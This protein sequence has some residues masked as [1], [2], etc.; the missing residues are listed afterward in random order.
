M[1]RTMLYLPPKP[2]QWD[3]PIS[4][5]EAK[6]ADQNALIWVSLETPSLEESN[7]V[8]GDIFHFH[9][10][11]IEDSQSEGYQTPKL[12]EFENYT[13]I[14]TM[15]PIIDTSTGELSFEE[16]N[17]F[18][19]PN[20]VVTISKHSQ[21]RVSE[22]IRE[23]MKKDS[24]LIQHGSDFF[25]HALIDQMV[26][27]L[28]LP[29]EKL[30]TEIEEIEDRLLV[31]SN[32]E[33]LEDVLRHKH[34][35]LQIRR[36]IAP[37]REVVNRLS[38]GDVKFIDKQ[39]RIYFRDIYDHLV[40]AHDWTEMLRDAASSALDVYLNATSL[41]LNKI[42]KALA[43]VSTIFLPLSFLA[44]VW[45]MNFKFMPEINWIY[46]YPLAITVF[47]TV[48]GIMIYVFKRRNWF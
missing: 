6:L 39:A 12:D 10:L 2:I 20:F 1:I 14:I 47:L 40:R 43:I 29:M 4:E 34:T 5:L 45:G 19:G 37:M 35:I 36:S 41:Q 23:R 33:I 25:T 22:I 8:L 18:L 24:R 16:Y 7:Q 31:N 48:V 42:M 15:A 13:F 32:P 46:G 9:P 38:R 3:F 26:D 27:D 44:G 28:H 21:I 17:I 11:A 30:E